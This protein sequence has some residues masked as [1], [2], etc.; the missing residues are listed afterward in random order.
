MVDFDR[1]RRL[2]VFRRAEDLLLFGRNRRVL[3]DEFR[4]DAA[5]GFDPQGQR[6]DVEE[7]DVFDFAREDAAL[8]RRADR[9]DFVGINAF[10]RF[11]VEDLL[12]RFLNFRDTGGTA[13]EDDFVDVGG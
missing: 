11:F 12:D 3:F 10:V 6:R 5:E 2:I 4:H 1:N 13:D 7:Q 9:D 8:N